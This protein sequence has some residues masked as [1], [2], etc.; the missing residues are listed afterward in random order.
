MAAD[1][2]MMDAAEI[3]A[4]LPRKR[5][6]D[7]RQRHIFW[8]VNVD[9]FVGEDPPAAL[10]PVAWK[11]ARPGR[12]VV[13]IGMGPAGL[14]AALRLLE[15]GVKPVILE[16]GKDHRARRRDI[17]AIFQ[18]HRVDPDSNFG[19]GEGGAGTFS[20]GKLY[21]RAGKRGD[22][23]RILRILVQHGADADILVDAH[24]HVGS[25]RLWR[26]VQSMRE[27]ILARGGEIHFGAR[28]D[29]FEIEAGRLLGVR[30][31]GKEHRGDAVLLA[32][33][34]SARDLFEELHRRGI[35][36]EA[37]PFALGVRIEHPQALIN[38]FQYRDEAKNPAL[39]AAAYHAA[40]QA[41]GRGVY[42]FCMCPGGLMV[43]AA[44]AMGE[45]VI[46]GM[47]M[48]KRNSYWANAGFVA[49]VDA[50]DWAPWAAEG[51]LAGMRLQAEVEK[52]MAAA[53]GGTQRAPAQ[54]AQDFLKG[55]PSPTLPK[56]SYIPGHVNAP[57]HEIL[58]GWLVKALQ[59]G[60]RQFEK[61]MPGFAGTDAVMV[62]P[63]SRTS[64]P[65]RIP[66]DPQTLMHPQCTGLFPCGEGAGFAGGIVSAAIDGEKSAE[67][68]LRYLGV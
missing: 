65:V 35:P 40:C 31:G 34:H 61:K 54:R 29:G 44:T 41:E 53:A 15:E 2:L 48:A 47:S 24:P 46:N 59:E 52:N 5:S 26:T 68:I 42:S 9:V 62:A 7:A 64:S 57:L 13:I 22:P 14:F 25:D 12:A 32:A 17:K 37:K 3:R 11:E 63:E 56:T 39:P 58:P 1:H 33:G 27:T 23:A 66:R 28:V 18:E 38:R 6:L 20:D 60:L 30:A 36:L 45:I 8:R 49:S 19:F 43:P 10:P 55:R 21:T 50:N 16:R 67:G 51:P 4:V